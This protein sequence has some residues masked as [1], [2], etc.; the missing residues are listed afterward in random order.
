MY[1][2]IYDDFVQDKKHEKELLKIEN[3]LADLGIT[4]KVARL[5]L[6]KRAD[7][8]I[9]DEVKHGVKTVVIVGN[10]QTLCKVLSAV[11]ES[12]V[13]FGIIPLGKSNNIAKMMG[14]PEG[15]DACNVISKRL[16]EKIDVGKCN[17]YRFITGIPFPKLKAEMVIDQSYILTPVSGGNVVVRNLGVGEV[18]TNKQVADPKDGQLEVLV[19]VAGR[20]G[21][22]GGQSK[23]IFK[24][25]A[26]ETKDPITVSFDGHQIR[27]NKFKILLDRKKLKVIVGKDRMF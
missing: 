5:A 10:D 1:Y 16:I 22:K 26:F 9:L 6:F 12:G 8:L 17:G 2:Y 25:L 24:R 11:V 4:G 18:I 27:N 3:R 19:D 13:V 14:V 21:K 15:A 23:V 20:W 7:E